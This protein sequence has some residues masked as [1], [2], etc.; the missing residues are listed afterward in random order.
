MTVDIN[1]TSETIV[2][3]KHGRSHLKAVV[4]QA[5]EAQK[6]QTISKDQIVELLPMVHK[7]AQRL[8]TYLKPP[9]SFDDLASAGT[10]GLIKAARDYN[11]SHDTEFQTYAY[12]RI[13]GAIID[14]LRR[15]SFVPSPVNKEIQRTIKA[16]KEIADQTGTTPSDEQLAE[17]LQISLEKLHETFESARAQYFLSIDNNAENLPVLGHILE[18]QNTSSPDKHLEKTE[19]S[20]KLAEAIKGLPQKQKQVILLYYNQNLTM[21]QIA[22]VLEITEPRVSQLHSGAIFNLSVKLRQLKYDRE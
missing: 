7:I 14:E 10:I 15:W 19:L 20:E 16:S 4:K 21:K 11:P 6:K 9:L 2:E 18:D 17:K 22:E 3:I 5:Y 13:K 12:I 8:I 1:N